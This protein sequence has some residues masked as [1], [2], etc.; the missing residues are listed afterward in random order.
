ME[1]GEMRVEANISVSNSHEFGTKVEVKNLNSFRAVE[2]AIT[3]EIER[4]IALL[5][6]GKQ[7]EQETRGWDEAKQITFS[8]RKKESSNDYRY[9]PDPDLPKLKISEVKEFSPAVIM[10]EMPELPNAHRA[11]LAAYNLQEDDVEAYVADLTLSN[12]FDAVVSG[13]HG[14]SKQVQLASNYITSDLLGILKSTGGTLAQSKVTPENIVTLVKMLD[15]GEISS[16]GAKDILAI[17][18]VSGGDPRTVASEENLLQE[19]DE[20]ALL[21]IARQIISENITVADDY[22]AGKESALQFFVGQG[23][24]VTK[25]AANPQ[26]LQ[27][28]FRQVLAE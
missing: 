8:Q 21:E 13:L 26:I 25:G 20:K 12:F 3:Y 16:R 28:A 5:E 2:K 10:S 18:H 7:V 1:K 19:S 6:T 9:F 14:E 17:L 23:M 27:N 4:Q 24:R 15:S 22:R 11:R